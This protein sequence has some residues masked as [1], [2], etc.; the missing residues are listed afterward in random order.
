MKRSYGWALSGLQSVLAIALGFIAV[1]LVNLPAASL[2]EP[3]FPGSLDPDGMPR[4]A[5]AQALFLPI[6]FLAGVAGAFVVVLVAPRAPVAHALVFGAL[7][8]VG[9][10]FVVV[11]Y[12]E[13]WPLWFAALVVLTVPPQVWLGAVLGV[14][15]QRRWAR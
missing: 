15:A 13:I 14:R 8:V 1:I 5:P 3:L 6:I 4:T 12:A 9:D 10:L 2:V 11:D 7:A